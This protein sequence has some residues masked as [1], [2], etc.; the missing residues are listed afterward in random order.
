M[1]ADVS[2][3]CAGRWEGR[4]LTWLCFSFFSG[5]SF[6]Y[7]WLTIQNTAN[8]QVRNLFLKISWLYL[9]RF[10]GALC[11]LTP[12]RPPYLGEG[13]YQKIQKK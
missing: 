2:A 11:A 13:K 10:P 5:A 12:P 8:R 9:F 1:K 3:D 7:F 4:L 6:W